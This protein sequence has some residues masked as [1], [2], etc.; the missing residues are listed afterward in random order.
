[1]KL[2]VKIFIVLILLLIASLLVII[3][4]FQAKVNMEKINGFTNIQKFSMKV[5]E[6]T[7]Q[8]VAKI[9]Q[10]IGNKEAQK[11]HNVQKNTYVPTEK[12]GDET[13]E[14]YSKSKSENTYT[15]QRGDTFYSISKKFYQT[16][17]YANK[18]FEYNKDRVKKPENLRI[19]IQLK[20][21]DISV[22]VKKNEIAHK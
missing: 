19:G 21:P 2:Q 17:K 12:E 5:N 18:L 10:N 3:D 6:P 14:E 15:V 20:I 4:K 22:L 8:Q 11:E 16:S 1:M 9:V 13:N 7:S